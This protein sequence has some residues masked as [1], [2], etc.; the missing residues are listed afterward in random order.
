M[1]TGGRLGIEVKG[2]QLDDGFVSSHPGS[3]TGHHV[4]LAVSDTGI[5]MDAATQEHIFEP[6]FTTKESG[7]GTGLG[8]ASVYGIIK[9]AGGYIEV[10]SRLG[11]GSVSEPTFRPSRATHR[12][13][14][15]GSPPAV[16]GLRQIRRFCLSKTSPP[17]ASSP[18]ACSRTADTVSSPS[19][20]PASR[21]T[22]RS[23]T[24]T[25]TTRL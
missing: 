23:A 10:Q 20:I 1:P 12:R 9:Q 25:H 15:Y 22:L 5:G 8:L 24:R 21:L 19:A 14:R 6:F 3:T 18:N 4:L 17:F 2:V 16:R 7:E 13:R 11:G